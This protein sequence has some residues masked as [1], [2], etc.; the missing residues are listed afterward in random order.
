MLSKEHRCLVRKGSHSR[1][2]SR[3]LPYVITA[4]EIYKKHNELK[5][6]FRDNFI[7]EI[8]N[9]TNKGLPYTDEEL[10]VIVMYSAD[11]YTKHTSD[12]LTVSF[13]KERK[14]E[15]CKKLLEEANIE[16]E[17]KQL[18]NKVTKIK[19]RFPYAYKNMSC[20]YGLNKNQLKVICDEVM[21]WDGNGKQYT[22][23][24]KDN[25]DFVQYAYACNGIRASIDSDNRKEK[26]KN[27]KCYRVSIT[28]QKPRVQLAGTPKTPINIVK[29]KDGFKYCFTT[30]SGF[31]VMRRNGHICLTGNCGMLT[32]KLGHID[33]NFE[34]LDNTIRLEVPSGMNV[35]DDIPKDKKEYILN[36]ILNKL[37]CKN[38]INIDRAIKSIGTLG[39]GNHFIEIDQDSE[40]CKYLIIHTG[41]RYLGKQVA[42]YY[43]ELAYNKLSNNREKKLEVIEK[44]TK[45]GRQKDIENELKKIPNTKISK[46]LAY[47][48]GEDFNN[49][50]NDMKLVQKYAEINR[51][52]IAKA[53]IDN[54][55]VNN[56]DFQIESFQTIHN[57]ID[58]DNM[59]LRKGA[60]SAQK[61][62][63][64]LI[65]LNMRDGCLIGK[66]KGNSEWN[67]SAPHGAGRI[68]SRGKA[69]E[70]IT[71]DEFKDSMKNVWS[72]SVCESTIDESPMSYKPIEDILDNI[73]DSIEIIDIIKPIYNF[74]ANN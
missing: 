23:T 54:F 38:N 26:Y 3:D 22:S 50:I 4:E 53:I 35:F 44:L 10:R 13:K 71:L 27:G 17:C 62:E 48:E 28:N 66:G 46:H 45:E 32:V 18:D 19:F 15:R 63:V 24:I 12:L 42:T 64:V 43:Q 39:G 40:G 6:G 21:L 58:V 47:V 1:A 9:I 5:L 36:E 72:T 52:E 25:V 37:K 14:I 31:W 8:P 74:K 11:G 68:L 70:L 49:Y 7:C 69:K 55:I 33:I 29:S 2:V 51:C 65:P 34:E 59:I 61:D 30:S 67:Y 41:S 20:L 56:I 60:I 57:Y 16:Y 73:G